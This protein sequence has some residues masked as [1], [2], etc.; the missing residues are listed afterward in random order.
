MGAAL[1]HLEERRELI[2]TCRRMNALG[3]NQGSSGNA[4]LRVGERILITPSGLAYDEIEPEDV[5]SLAFD[6]SYT[7]PNGN[8]RPSSE[9]HFHRDILVARPEFDAVVHTHGIAVA[10]LA[11]MGLE[12]PAFHYMVAVAGGDSIRCAPYATFGTE[13]LSHHAV[14]ALEGRKA[15]LLANHGQIACGQSLKRALALAVEVETLAQMY[16]RV[17]QIGRPKV[18]P[19]AE[20]QV[21]IGRFSK[22]YGS[23]RAFASDTPDADGTLEADGDMRPGAAAQPAPEPQPR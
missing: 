21:V 19:S 20:M 11:C 4:S 17:L 9:W 8:R 10:T 5:V 16:W 6:G 12:I 14:A 18:L 2:E 15:C 7:S 22:G 1:E 3:I 13:A 23:G